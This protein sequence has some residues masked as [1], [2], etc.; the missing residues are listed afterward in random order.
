MTAQRRARRRRRRGPRPAARHSQSGTAPGPRWPISGLRAAANRGAPGAGAQLGAAGHGSVGRRRVPARRGSP[1]AGASVP[2]PTE[3]PAVAPPISRSVCRPVQWVEAVRHRTQKRAFL[4]HALSSAS[5]VQGARVEGAG[6]G[7]ESQHL[8]DTLNRTPGLRPIPTGL[9]SRAL[10]RAE[11]RRT[12]RTPT[13]CQLLLSVPGRRNVEPDPQ[14]LLFSRGRRQY[15]EEN[16]PKRHYKIWVSLA[17][18][19]EWTQRPC[20]GRTP[21]TGAEIAQFLVMSLTIHSCHRC[22]LCARRM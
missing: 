12:L 5:C 20:R 4:Q 8:V 19:K 17:P 21:G 3:M 18:R 11:V 9:A 13:V 7:L 1:P 16:D 2:A 15:T 6:P 22:L 10:P 14:D